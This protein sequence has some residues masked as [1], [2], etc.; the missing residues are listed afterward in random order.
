MFSLD[1]VGQNEAVVFSLDS[2]GQNEG[3]VRW[4]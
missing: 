2:V 1:S 4:C 3:W